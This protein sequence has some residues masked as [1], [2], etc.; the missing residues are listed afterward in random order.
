MKLYKYLAEAERIP[1]GWGTAWYNWETRQAVILPIPLHLILGL[2]YSSYWK[3]VWC[4]RPTY[5]EK[6][7]REAY[8]LGQTRQKERDNL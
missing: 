1:F 4:L 3:L 2:M 8:N 7:L 5:R 6:S